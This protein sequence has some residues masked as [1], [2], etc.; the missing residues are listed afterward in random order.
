MMARTSLATAFGIA[1]GF[2]QNPL[3]TDRTAALIAADIDR[4]RVEIRD[5]DIIAVR[6]DFVSACQGRLLP[7]DSPDV[8]TSV[9][10]ATR[11]LIASRTFN[12]TPVRLTFTSNGTVE[13]NGGH[14]AK[15]QTVIAPVRHPH[16][17]AAGAGAWL[18]SYF[19]ADIGVVIFQ[20]LPHPF[21]RGQRAGS[22]ASYGVVDQR[23]ADH[24]AATAALTA[25]E[26]TLAIIRAHSSSPVV[27]DAPT[28]HPAETFDETGGLAPWFRL[29]WAEACQSALGAHPEG[30]RPISGTRH[31]D[32]LA[33]VSRAIATVRSG[34]ARVPGEDGWR[35]VPMG[36]GARVLIEP[37]T[38]TTVED[39]RATIGLGALV[40]RFSSALWIE[41]LRADTHVRT[42]GSGA[43]VRIIV[44]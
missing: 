39:P 26:S 16:R 35:F 41:G 3:D 2:P 6:A 28:E 44:P 42:D 1:A 11:A 15:G 40:E 5:D 24:A 34:P 23:T 10:E 7:A 43:D 4:A 9:A 12:G 29:G 31:D 32:I 36:S 37:A 18:R 38:Q 21:R 27:P 19:S 14:R 30:L 33:H 17:W 20:D 25:E 22:L 13:F 8:E